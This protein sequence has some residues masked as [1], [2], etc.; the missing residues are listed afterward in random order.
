MAQGFSRAM[1]FMGWKVPDIDEDDGFVDSFEEEAPAQAAQEFQFQAFPG[2]EDYQEPTPASSPLRRIVTVHPTSYGDARLIGEAF[3]DGTPVI[4]NLTDLPDAEA[5][6]IIDFAAG[7]VF[8]LYG[9]IEKV[10][11]RV[12][13]LSP[14]NVEVSSKAEIRSSALFS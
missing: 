14:A 13:L 9:V 5:R 6:R 2:G 3:R 8:G 7:L 12:F 1:E 4:I 10:T 11:P